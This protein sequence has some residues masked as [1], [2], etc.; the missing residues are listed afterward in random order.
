M[1]KGRRRSF[2]YV[3]KSLSNGLEV[4]DD[5]IREQP[6]AAAVEMQP[7]RVEPEATSARLLVDRATEEVALENWAHDQQ[8][9]LVPGGTAGD[10]P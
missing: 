1:R 10:G 2:A 7:V 4:L 3:S 5:H 8:Q 9:V 6:G